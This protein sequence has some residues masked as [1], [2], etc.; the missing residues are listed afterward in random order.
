MFV[1]LAHK[2]AYFPHFR[3]SNEF[4]KKYMWQLTHCYYSLLSVLWFFARTETAVEERKIFT[5]TISKN[6]IFWKSF[7][8]HEYEQ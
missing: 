3:L 5:I 6:C 1:L 2:K 7:N 4:E 8:S